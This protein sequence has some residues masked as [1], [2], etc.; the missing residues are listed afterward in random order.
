MWLCAP[1]SPNA[2]NKLPPVAAFGGFAAVVILQYGAT[3]ISMVTKKKEE[4]G[5]GR[6][7]GYERCCLPV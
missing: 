2:E 1:L 3:I 5:E 7:R 4:S 6:V